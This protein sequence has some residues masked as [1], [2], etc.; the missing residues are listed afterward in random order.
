MIHLAKFVAVAALVAG[1]GGNPDGP[2]VTSAS[3]T[4]F[5]SIH[6]GTSHTCGI[7]ANE[8]VI[9][10]GWSAYGQTTPTPGYY[11]EI[12]LGRRHTCGV[13][14]QDR[15]LCWGDTDRG[16]LDAPSSALTGLAAGDHHTCGL[17]LGGQ[18]LCWGDNAAG[19][20]TP[21]TTAFTALAAS[22]S[23][24]CGLTEAGS[25]ECWG[26][27]VN[28]PTN[29]YTA[30]IDIG[31][32]VDGGC[33]LQATGIPS[34]WGQVADGAPPEAFESISVGRYHACALNSSGEVSCWG[35][36]D[37][38]ATAVPEGLKA[39]MVD[40]GDNFT[41]VVDSDG[42]GSCWGVG[43]LGQTSITGEAVANGATEWIVGPPDITF[44]E[45]VA[46]GRAFLFR[47]K[48]GVGLTG[49]LLLQITKPGIYAYG[50]TPTPDTLRAGRSINS[51]FLHT[52]TESG[53]KVEGSFT[54]PN[55]IIG[56]IVDSRELNSTDEI[57]ARSETTYDTSDLRGSILD[58]QDNDQ[59]VISD[60]A[61]TITFSLDTSG[62]GDTFRILTS[63]TQPTDITENQL[64][65]NEFLMLD[66]CDCEEELLEQYETQDECVNDSIWPHAKICAEV[67][68]MET[69]P[70][71]D[72]WITCMTD[73]ARNAGACINNETCPINGENI[74]LS[75]YRDDLSQCAARNEGAEEAWFDA[76]Y[77]CQTGVSSV[78]GAETV[79]GTGAGT[80]RGPL[81]GRGDDYDG[82]AFCA[83]SGPDYTIT[84][85]APRNGEFLFSIEASSTPATIAILESCDA[86][87]ALT[88]TNELNSSLSLVME[89]DEEVV[90]LID[91]INLD[92]AGEVR[93]DVTRVTEQQPQ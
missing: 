34:C 68:W 23:H 33:V 32:S 20:S 27:E 59:I 90:L 89:K 21:P 44:G 1:C 30:A 31:L 38:G 3:R 50:A 42:H 14:R 10:W 37:Q 48:Q 17:T 80:W 29:E 18:A 93:L 86:D 84:Y 7:D 47:E 8:D 69:T 41:C 35:R 4:T 62:G 9:C 58:L 55:P 51:W 81:A 13:D 45:V 19:Q 73:A 88:C 79:T 40:A 54:L 75:R 65:R 82:E 53:G 74:C 24:T 15:I 61:L 57:F 2:E 78:C 46:D 26:A 64:L 25:V 63:D 71:T 39:Q 5:S 77:A 56:L 91:G 72:R 6:S 67:A 11:K 70:L 49:D 60:D 22:E 87:A 66:R 36:E 12:D 85:V 16:Q 43:A 92:T 76:Y 83:S 28:F 52:D